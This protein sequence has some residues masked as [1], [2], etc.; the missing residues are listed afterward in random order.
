M[1]AIILAA[2]RG[3]RMKKMTQRQPKCFAKLHDKRLIEWQMD[4]LM[5][6]GVN[7]I[8]I[9]RGYMGELFDFPCRYFDN[10]RW[11]E[12]NMLRS[13]CAARELLMSDVCIVSYSDIVYSHK[14]VGLLMEGG[15]HIAVTYDPNWLRLWSL[16]FAEPLSDAETFQLDASNHVKEIGGRASSVTEIEGQYMG[17]LRIT[18]RGW[19]TIEGLLGQL[20][21][22]EVD[23][24]DM[25]QLLKEL[26]ARDVKVKGVG[27]GEAWYEV[28]SADDLAKYNA[29]PPEKLF[30]RP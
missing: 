17:L 3:G 28:D 5:A 14:A 1:K 12:T 23:R 10:T 25:T 2:G 22:E 27:I 8:S 13:L 7:D 19:R 11:Q 16:R 20:A 18:P 29:V 24:M 30:A 15:S 4:A 21:S 9:V 26:I 6:S